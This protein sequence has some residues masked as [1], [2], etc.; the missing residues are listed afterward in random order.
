MELRHALEHTLVNVDLRFG[1]EENGVPS[2]RMTG[3]EDTYNTIIRDAAATNPDVARVV[4]TVFL[5]M[6]AVE[7]MMKFLYQIARQRTVAKDYIY[8][9]FF[10]APFVQRFCEQEGIEPATLEAARRRCPFLL[11]VL[12]ACRVLRSER[13]AVHVDTLMLIPALVQQH[14]R[15]D[16][17]AIM[18]R[19]RG[20]IDAWPTR[21]ETLEGEDLSIL[22]ELF[23]PEFLTDKYIWSDLGSA[24]E[25]VR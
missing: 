7:Q 19:F 14:P 18:R 21:A 16:P 1:V 9:N 10:E 12:A 24:L 22:R 2:T 23:G 25:D 20:V 17:A 5:R 8:S 13:S 4:N 11:N 15:E 6:S 3:D